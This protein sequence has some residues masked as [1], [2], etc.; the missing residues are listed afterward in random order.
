M[1]AFTPVAKV[2]D[3]TVGRML[4]VALPSGE[5]VLVMN[6]DGDICALPDRCSHEELELSAGELLPDGT[7]ECVFHGARFDCRT[8]RVCSA[9]ATLDLATYPVRVEDG[10]I[11]VGPRQEPQ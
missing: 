6:V 7:I 2:A 3:L 4:S 10:L 1:S 8:G 5:Q 11:L 9:P